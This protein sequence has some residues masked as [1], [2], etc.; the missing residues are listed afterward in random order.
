M[1]KD[2]DL[3][4]IISAIVVCKAQ[5]GDERRHAV[6]ADDGGERATRWLEHEQL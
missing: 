5:E 2:I 6:G 1:P 4:T 3:E